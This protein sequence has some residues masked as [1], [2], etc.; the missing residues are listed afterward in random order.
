MN[1][2]VLYSDDDMLV[3]N[4]PAGVVV[5]RAESVREQTVQDWV[6]N[7]IKDQ[8]SKIEVAEGTDF[9]KRSGVVHRIDKETSGI[10]LIAK[11]ESAF[12]V[13][14]TQFKER[15]VKKTYHALLHGMLK[16]ASGT[17]LAPIGRLP[18]NRKRF[19]VVADGKPAKTQYRVDTYYQLKNVSGNQD[20]YSLVFFFPESGRT[21]QIRAHAKY[22]GHPLVADSFYAGKR[23]L[24]TDRTWCPRLFLHAAAISF[25][26]PKTHKSISIEAPLPADLKQALTHLKPV[27][28]A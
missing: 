4:K 23:G 19:G 6:E 7:K 28:K 17:I 8:R 26:H 11:N 5:N 3:I 12:I 24:R 9:Y 27:D 21:H 2:P 22:S 20:R 25:H 1:I 16:P 18:W 15:V 10:L 13:L 14:Q